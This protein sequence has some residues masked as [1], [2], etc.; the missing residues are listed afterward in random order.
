MWEY[1]REGVL[2]QGAWLPA[3]G[4]CARAPPS[5][6]R[7]KRLAFI[8]DSVTRG[9]VFDLGW[10][11]CECPPVSPMATYR[12][13]RPNL[14]GT[15]AALCCEHLWRMQFEKWNRDS[16]LRVDALNL[17][18]DVFWNAYVKELLED[19]RST[20][21][22]ATASGVWDALSAP[23][24]YDAILLNTGLWDVGIPRRQCTF[25]A[26]LLGGCLFDEAVSD[27]C[28]DMAL[29]GSLFNATL[30][31]RNPGLR[32]TLLAWSMT[33]SEPV[34]NEKTNFELETIRFPHEGLDAVDTCFLSGFR[35]TGFSTFNISAF[36]RAPPHLRARLEREL[37]GRPD[38]QS[39]GALLTLDGYHP[40]G[41][42]RR[43]IIAELINEWGRRWA[44]LKR[45]PQPHV[46]CAERGK[47]ASLFVPLASFVGASAVVLL[48]FR[49]GTH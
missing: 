29:L 28:D 11:L 39:P 46:L 19:K 38:G 35:K 34:K 32:D 44:A 24:L 25:K 33:S 9:I 13:A 6:L 36:V 23:G 4:P 49:Y 14:D 30:A 5:V 37:D 8:G 22:S 3:S 45:R 47:A 21:S 43:A 1:S 15:K 16:T 26:A 42:T 41:I 10:D 12:Y 17:T 20:D 2:V 48:L 27:V 7:N 18:I 31:S 40:N